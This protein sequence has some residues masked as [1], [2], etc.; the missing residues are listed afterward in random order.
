M[1]R[2]VSSLTLTTIVLSS[3]IGCSASTTSG[4]L[5][6]NHNTGQIV[7][8][9]SKAKSLD[10]TPKMETSNYSRLELAVYEDAVRA[11]KEFK[12]SHPEEKIYGLS[13]CTDND[14][15]GF[16]IAANT[17]EGCLRIENKGRKVP[18]KLADLKPS[19]LFYNPG[20]WELKR[21]TNLSSFKILDQIWNEK[22]SETKT[23]K[24]SQVFQ[25]L[26]SG[27]KK[28]DS[29]GYFTGTASRDEMVLMVWI[30]DPDH[31]EWVVRWTRELN[32]PRA[33]AMFKEGYPF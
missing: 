30:H 28:F 10:S 9:E 18:R 16:Y 25:A 12:E 27:L 29:D 5:A 15:L 11:F 31:P 2:T 6:N 33:F 22:N 21:D 19:D 17:L 14:G 26:V 32:P 4:S 13:V 24:K 20:D 7:D 3:T 1:L 8:S 23:N